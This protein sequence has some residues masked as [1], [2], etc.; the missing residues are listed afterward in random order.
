MSKLHIS[1]VGYYSNQELESFAIDSHA[2][3]ICFSTT[4]PGRR[5]FYDWWLERNSMPL[6]DLDNVFT[7]HKPTAEQLP[8]YEELRASAKDFAA[9]IQRLVP[10]CADRTAA[11][12]KIREAVM[13]ANAAIAL[14]GKL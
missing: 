7:Y 3:L 10:D 2:D 4:L 1:E 9:T 14:N 13:T 11:I 6:I 5:W 12:R 8:I